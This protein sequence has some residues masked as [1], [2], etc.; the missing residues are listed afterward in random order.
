MV[1]GHYDNCL[2]FD[3]RHRLS[4]DACHLYGYF[5]EPSQT[6]SWFR[7]LLLSCTCLLHSW[8]I[9]RSNS[10]SQLKNALQTLL[11]SCLSIMQGNAWLSSS[12]ICFLPVHLS[13]HIL[14]SKALILAS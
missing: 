13:L 10:R 3:S 9:K 2:S 11:H 7:Q 1:G 5:L 4:C 14:W 6:A 8:D 12:D